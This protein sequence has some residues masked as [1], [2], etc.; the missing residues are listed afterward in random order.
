MDL[1]TPLLVTPEGAEP[2][3]T[4]RIVAERFGKRHA[5]VLRAIRALLADPEMRSFT[6]RNFAFSTYTDPTGRAVPE[7]RLTKDGFAFVAM[8]FTGRRANQWKRAFLEA[9]N[10]MAEQLQQQH[11]GLWQ[12][13]LALEAREQGSKARASIG[14]Q[15]M[16]ERKREIPAIVSERTRLAAAIQPRL[17]FDRFE[18]GRAC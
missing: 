4:S 18:G 16:L 1:R 11:L 2:T 15:L 12:Q 17:P 7:Y 13:F 5:D 10:T 6:E 8:G 9:F 14:S 3:T